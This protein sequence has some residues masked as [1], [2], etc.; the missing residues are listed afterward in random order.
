MSAA[1]A[2][3]TQEASQ[4]TVPHLEV[5]ITAC[6]DFKCYFDSAGQA[7]NMNSYM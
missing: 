4:V 7:D 6:E 5:A 1:R 2:L 3:A